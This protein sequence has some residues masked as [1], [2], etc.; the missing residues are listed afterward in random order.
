MFHHI[1]SE[2]VIFNNTK[3]A[4]LQKSEVE[5]TLAPQNGLRIF[6]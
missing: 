3:V 4:A 2:R 1:L 6:P 5:V